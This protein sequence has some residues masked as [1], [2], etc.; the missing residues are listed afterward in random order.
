M[1]D[2]SIITRLKLS[3]QALNA[4][5]APQELTLTGSFSQMGSQ[6]VNH[7]KERLCLQTFLYDV[8]FFPKEPKTAKAQIVSKVKE[9]LTELYTH[10]PKALKQFY[11]GAAQHPFAQEH[12]LSVLHFVYLDNAYPMALLTLRLQKQ[13][14]SGYH[15]CSFLA[16]PNQHS[17]HGNFVCR[18]SDWL[19]R[20]L[21]AFNYCPVII[22]L[23]HSNREKYPNTVISPSRVGQISNLTYLSSNGLFQ[24]NNAANL[25]KNPSHSKFYYDRGNYF[26]QILIHM[27]QSQHFADLKNKILHTQPNFGFINNIVG[28]NPKEAL[29]I[30]VTPNTGQST[31]KASFF[32]QI[33]TTNTFLTSTN[34]FITPNW[35]TRLNRAVDNP[36]PMDSITHSKQRL[37]NITQQAKT[38]TSS[39]SPIDIQDL[40]TTWRHFLN[41]PSDKTG[42]CIRLHDTQPPHPGATFVQVIADTSHPPRL[43][44]SFQQ[45]PTRH[46]SRQCTAPGQCAQFTPWKTKTLV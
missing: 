29:S 9:R 34:H 24:A 25:F 39:G 43:F 6:L 16:L 44:Y 18:N 8:S 21:W 14:H 32:Y 35:N 12:K 36:L 46:A 4:P 7:F 13:I 2:G 38:L 11:Q 19:G 45:V 42:A 41:A 5:N 28:P 30:E 10:A 33:R 23:E 22:S 37:L 26:S 27:M 1:L 40:K 31:S 17:E 15:Q 20:F 3:V